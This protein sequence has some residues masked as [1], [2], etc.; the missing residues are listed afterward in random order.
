MKRRNRILFALCAVSLYTASAWADL[1]HVVEQREV[2]GVTTVM[3]D[4]TKITGMPWATAPAPSVDGAIFTHWTISTQQDFAARDAWGR[5]YDAP[6]F[7]L[8]EDT[9]LTVHYLPATRDTD[10]DGVPDGYEL[11]WYGNLDQDAASDTDG[12]G[13]T[14][15]EEIANG[16]NPLMPENEV[17]GAI[18]YGDGALLLYN[19]SGYA[20]AV[21]R[22]EPATLFTTSEE[23]LRPGTY[24]GTGTYSP[25]SSDF[26]YW[27]LNGVPV[28]DA[29][30][31]AVDR[32][33]LM[34]PTGAVELVAH[35]ESDDNTR[36]KLYWYGRTDIAMDS[37]TD[38]DGFTFA[39][40]LANGT[41]PLM[42]DS[43]VEGPIAYADSELLQY[44][45]YNLQ[46]YTIRSDPEGA[47]FETIHD[48]APFGTFVNATQYAPN[49]ST[50]ACWV[51][52][53]VEQRDAWGRAVEV[54]SLQ[55]STNAQELVA[56]VIED[57][58]ARLSYYWYGRTDVAMDSDTDGDGFTF[59]EEIANGTNPL[60]P[61]SAVEGPIAYADSDMLEANLQPFD[62]AT[63]AVVDDTF[64][65]LFTSPF[66]GNGATSRTFGLNA[67]PVVTDVNGDGLFDLVI[68]YDGGYAV[69][70]NGGTAGNPMFT[71]AEGV[72]TNGLDLAQG[73][74]AALEGLTLDVPPTGAVSCAFGDVDQDGIVDLLVS[75]AEG[76][77]WFYKRAA[78]DVGPYHLQHKVWAGSHAG[79]APGLTI[80]L[81]D[82]DGDGD[83]DCVCGTADGKLMLL[84]DPRVGKPT[85]VQAMAGVNSVVLTWDPNGNSRVRGYGIYRGVDTN[86]YDRIE[87]LW[88]LPRYRDVPETI[89]D[90][91]YRVTSLSR[92]YTSGNST[93]TISESLPTDAVYVQ[94]R[95]SVWLTGASAFTGSNVTVVVLM[96]NTMGISAQGLTMTFTYDPA[97]LEPV[98]MRTTGLTAGL[99]SGG[100]A[101]VPSAGTWR[102]AS[103]GGEIETGAGR[104][105]LLD[106]TV[107]PVHDVDETTVTLKAA[108][109]K[110]L[111]GR[112][113][114]LDLPKSATIEISDSH[115]LVP[116]LVAVHVADA[117]VA[118]ETEFELPV[119]VTSTE[120]LTNFTAEVTWDT[121]LLE[122]RG[123]PPMSRDSDATRCVPPVSI[124]TVG[125]D[126]A[127]RFYAKDPASSATNFTAHVGLTNIVAVDCHDFT[128]QADD[129]A[130]TVLIRNVHPWVPAYV[131][132]STEDQK[133]ATLETV[134]V[135][136]RVTSDTALT[137]G[138]FTVT[139]D[140]DA[141]ELR[142]IAGGT[143][144]AV[145]GA[146]V[147]VSSTGDF[148]LM[149]LAKNQHDIS[150]TQVRLTE[151]EVTDTHGFVVSPKV[152]V[153]ATV[154]IRDAHPLVPAQVAMTLE[155]V[156]AK[157][158]TEFEMTLAVSSTE[159]LTNLTATVEWD[160]TLLEL[161][162]IA[163]GTQL[164]ASGGTDAQERVPP[165]S[166]TTEGGGFTLRFYARENHTV[167][168]TQVTVRPQGG[169]DHNGLAAVLP[170]E[171]K[172][173]VVLA[174][175]NPWKPATVSV[176]VGV[177]NEPV[178]TRT[179]FE[180]PVKLTSSERLTNFT[181]FVAWDAD[182]L[183]WRGVAGGA[184]LAAS[185]GA[186]A[187]ERVPP[188]SMTT[189]GGDFVL[190]FYAKD[191]HNVTRTTVR[192]TDMAAVDEHGLTANTIADSEGTVLIRDAHPL[193]PAQVAMTLEDVQAKTET[194]FEM[195]LA[196]SS[197]EALTNLTAT[198]EWDTTLLELRGIAGG[199]QLAASGGTDAQ[200]R[201]PPVSVTTE[202]G[203]FTLRFYARENHTVDLTQVTVRPQGGWDHN[204]LA[205]VLPAEV[206]GT[207]VLADSNPWKPATVSVGV[208][209]GNE[210][211]DTRT[212]FEVPVKLTS[213]ERLTNFTAFVAWDA[214]VLEWR[215][216]AGGAQLA[217]SGGA[218]AQERV[219]P[220]SMTTAGGDFVLKF[221]AKDRHNVT[222][223]TVRLTDMAAVDE[224][225]LTANT[226]A[227]AE[228]TVLIRDAHPLVPAQVAVGVVDT[229][230]DTL[231]DVSVPVRVTTTKPLTN[232][233]LS[234][235]W[236]ADVLEWRG[237]QGGKVSIPSVG[238]T[239]A[240]RCVPPVLISTAGG[241]FVLKFYA[242]DQHAVTETAITLGSASAWCA[243]GLAAVVTCTDGRVFI[244]DSNPP[245]AP[246]MTLGAWS[247]RV[248]SGEAFQ[249]PIGRTSDG[250]LAD[251]TV[252][253]AWDKA[254]LTFDGAVDATKTEGVSDGAGTFT[255]ATQGLYSTNYL[256]FTAHTIRDLRTNVWVTV[257]AG[258]GTG[259][260]GLAAR[261]KTAFPLS[262]PVLI[263]REIG[264]YSPGDID[265][266][267]KLT[268]ADMAK[269][270]NFL[271]YQSLAKVNPSLA[272]RY[273]AWKLTGKALAAA[274]VNGDGKVDVN[275][276]SLLKQWIEQA[277]EME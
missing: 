138:M 163:G 66:A 83:L 264:K 142:D 256:A 200:E 38:G 81:V 127:L 56:K 172:G 9:T 67:R 155:D 201:V 60:M 48:Y 3:R 13:F 71:R 73:S 21:V 225:G 250:E 259:A 2:D 215:G 88:P 199:T 173:T 244:T 84:V 204:G 112:N 124:T 177:G 207:V 57:E 111:D 160:T 203:G 131:S 94:F 14:F 28:R 11:Y 106:F 4:E 120:V 128:V 183:E 125:G 18:A 46:P 220:V 25:T 276:V 233:V 208:G 20:S 115:P 107:R 5:A 80:A 174:D 35:T 6:R 52:N 68:L 44:N 101:S 157:T 236:D 194:E 224:H 186:D 22:S 61:D 100:T 130:G 271:K 251:L 50:F 105:L 86:A 69:Y 214:D 245:V 97:V 234:V 190:K 164:A 253:L 209:V 222:R 89:Q 110:A 268:D 31:R 226:I 240:T 168:L 109:V 65:E 191:R 242:K 265:G 40:E 181:A 262:I 248:L 23:W 267:G 149:F 273:A 231:Q 235:G 212:E 162:G 91:Y 263:V 210:P 243:D 146:S 8:Y 126:F 252:S 266:D 29:W 17:A 118:S 45:P 37:D 43:T 12:D 221:Y 26:A 275:D 159:A 76:R 241:D 95:P 213:S 1:V 141:L 246:N 72:S 152:P 54:L 170:A 179:E 206:K 77:I 51:L 184:Q 136:F 87:P 39:E 158:E 30:G 122:F 249:L 237:V 180:V 228:G 257:T 269:L 63:G 260:N 93:P 171:V 78:G 230:T 274:D 16:T 134:T 123:V 156:Q 182:V 41:N 272:N 187:Q 218:D 70:L 229:R 33:E 119:T 27:T 137:R 189:A 10:G 75:D 85:N 153:V 116:S 144:L 19:P 42:P 193:V 166:V 145:S 24:V 104:F 261:V 202:G 32:V 165:V 195:T 192:L 92:F 114:A 79:F 62:P 90:Y 219:P 58:A 147:S 185:G 167:D 47:L 132:V 49:T 7:E 227:D 148:A 175:S 198:V 197:T 98:G 161:R 154:L 96:N 216:V 151:A 238:D 239:D 108:T 139:W 15:A 176:G 255:F 205:A 135:P 53:G 117:S 217:A 258:G 232:L 64:D 129:A 34:M 140:E 254:F 196:V 113:V 169:W 103:L 270:Q 99:V 82:W 55:M 121:A 178:D 277:K 36:M 133:V 143:Q 188:V 211:V 150:Q 59:A 223:T 74:L 247:V 102:F